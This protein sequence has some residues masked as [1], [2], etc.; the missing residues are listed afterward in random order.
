MSESQALLV[1]FITLHHHYRGRLRNK[2]VRL[3]DEMSDARTDCL[4]LR[5]VQIT[6]AGKN[7]PAIECEELSLEKRSILVAIPQNG[8]QT[9]AQRLSK[10]QKKQRHGVVVVLPG[11]LMSGVMQVPRASVYWSTLKESGVLQPFIGLTNA[12]IHNAVFRLTP[13]SCPVAVVQRDAIEAI[14]F[15]SAPLSEMSTMEALAE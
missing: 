8:G 1:D 9:P 10:F 4:V 7:T 3:S 15:A 12:T 14:E 6:A 11:H 5:D 13:R 2:G